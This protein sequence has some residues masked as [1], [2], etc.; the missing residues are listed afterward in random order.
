ML[1]HIQKTLAVQVTGETA[2][3][4]DW[5]AKVSTVQIG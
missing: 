3:T 4:I 1:Y 5:M 2:K